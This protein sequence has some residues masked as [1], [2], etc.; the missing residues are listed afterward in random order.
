MGG[1]IYQDWKDNSHVEILHV[2]D[3]LNQ[4]YTCTQWGNAGLN[5]MPIIDDG[6]GY[7]FYDMFDVLGSYP[8]VAFINHEM[9]L[10]YRDHGHISQNDT[11]VLI[12]EMLSNISTASGCGC[13]DNTACNYDDGATLFDDSCEYQEENYDCDG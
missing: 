11:H 2:L 10:I 8:L 9:K 7:Y 4:P 5:G 1:A 3:D 6:I 12:T 13:T